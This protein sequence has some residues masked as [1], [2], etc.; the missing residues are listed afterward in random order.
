[1]KQ[2]TTK[3]ILLFANFI[4]LN[5]LLAQSP[6]H[7][8]LVQL[9][10]LPDN[11]CVISEVEEESFRNR[12]LSVIETIEAEAKRI[13]KQQPTQTQMNKSI[14][15]QTGISEENLNELTNSQDE[16]KGEKLANQK[17]QT[18][19]G[20]SLEEAKKMEQMSEKELQQWGENHVKNQSNKA[21]E[22]KNHNN[23]KQLVLLTTEIEKINA[24]LSTYITSWSNMELELKRQDQLANKELTECLQKVKNSAPK[25]KYQGEACIN[26]N[27]IDEYIAK[28]EK[29][30]HQTYC[31]RISPLKIQTLNHK[32]ADL[33][34][35]IALT[36]KLQT[37]QNDML[38]IQT[39]IDLNAT[40]ANIIGALALVKE[41][42]KEL[43]NLL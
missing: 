3:L 39:G 8:Y 1:M 21:Q 36:I 41:Y 38:K 22:G 27:E 14:S 20:V 43:Y 25:P 15:Q 17:M 35:M 24:E 42:A 30:C 31:N 16:K 10:P 34:K 12:I 29:L 11:I 4:F 7:K 28:N 9:P 40:E 18:E 2:T 26:Q 5:T 6:A 37:L 19:Y 33:Q 32:K 23:D 13:E